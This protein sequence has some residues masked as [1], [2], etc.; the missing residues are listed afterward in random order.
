MPHKI[1]LYST[2]LS[3]LSFNHRVLQE[4]RDPKV[5]VLERL[6]FLAIFS[7]NLDEFFRVKVAAIRS[8]KDDPNRAKLDFDPAVLL[9][10]IID[11]VHKQQM[12]FGD[13]YRNKIIPE[14]NKNNI[15]ILTEEE[16][17]KQHK[18]FAYT[19]YKTEIEPVLSS[20]KVLYYG[21][22]PF[23]ENRK[24]YIL[25]PGRKNAD[26]TSV[27]AEIPFG[28]AQ[29]FVVFP[30]EPGIIRVGFTDDLI[31]IFFPQGNKEIENKGYAIK[32]SRDAELNIEDEFS[33]NLVKK[34]SRSLK[35]RADGAPARFL[36][37]SAMPASLVK[38]M[39]QIWKL[40]DEDLMAGGK[41]H[42]FSDFFDFPDLAGKPELVYAPLPKIPLKELE[43]SSNYFKVLNKKDVLLHYPYHSF[44]H[45]INFLNASADSN[46]VTEIKITLYRVAG[47]SE[48]C[49]ALIRAL[50]KGK[51]V[52]AFFE[53]KARFDEE[54]NIFWAEE[55]RK[56]GAKVLYSFPGLKVHAKLCLVIR[57]KGNETKRYAYLSTGNFNEKTANVYTDFGLLTSDKK[58]TQEAARV[59]EIL[60]DMRKR[61][62]FSKLLIAPDKLR[63]E[64]Y[65]LID[66]EIIHHLQGKEAGIII[67]VNGLDDI[68]MI[69]KLY[70]ASQAGVQIQLIIRGICRLVPGKKGFSENIRITSIVDRFLEH[71]RL[72]WFRNAGNDKL[73]LSSADFMNRNLSRRI[74]VAYPVE[75]PE[76]KSRLMRIAT[77]YLNDNTK[78]RIIDPQHKNRYVQAKGALPV[79]AQTDIWKFY[80]MHLNASI[81]DNE[82]TVFENLKD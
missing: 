66:R 79:N 58:M 40:G 32:L 8:L 10:D 54:S 44:Q 46:S 72:Y 42:N 81:A 63:N 6:R 57:K 1:P 39:K 38:I 14:L 61:F 77:F 27:I 45:F 13:I 50:R 4:A 2:N 24:T 36:Y 25:F 56:A 35:N 37:D 74:E 62:D 71:H 34:I 11:T 43:D 3:W 19:H 16:I 33:G 68:E 73:Y 78:T 47:N 48:V 15:F 60:E 26:R 21:K 18:D 64:I 28:G 17:R 22:T 9:R 5:P 69:E 75:S 41:Y 55:L 67:K 23:L 70:E 59:F 53:V 76:L 20:V 12:E 52:T 80:S 30:S 31:R 82:K 7:N 51:K 29:R 65:K 49:K